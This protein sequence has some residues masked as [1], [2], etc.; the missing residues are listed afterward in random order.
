MKQ[1]PKKLFVKVD[2]AKG[3]EYF[4]ADSDIIGMVDVGQ[5]EKIGVYQLVGITFAEG[6]VKVG[7]S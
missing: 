2:G 3:E 5:K 7:K 6:V 4:V 1:L